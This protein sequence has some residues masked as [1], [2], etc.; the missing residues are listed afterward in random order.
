MPVT[1]ANAAA[2]LLATSV[3][4]ELPE[5]RATEAVQQELES[6]VVTESRIAD[7]VVEA[8]ERA[9]SGSMMAEHREDARMVWQPVDVPYKG[10]LPLA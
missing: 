10:S 2:C 7:G 9:G 1:M 5:E 3:T 8:T 4:V 6:S